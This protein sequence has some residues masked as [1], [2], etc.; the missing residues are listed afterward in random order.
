MTKPKPKLEYWRPDHIGAGWRRRYPQEN[1]SVASVFFEG[2]KW[3]G[4]AEHP[5]GDS[6]HLI[7]PEPTVDLARAAVDKKLCEF[8][9]E[10][11]EKPTVRVSS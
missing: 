10:L 8:G 9:W 11:K 7:P 6:G 3:Y 2:G 4:A 1:R 5:D